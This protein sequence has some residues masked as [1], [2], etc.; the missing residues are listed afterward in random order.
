[1]TDKKSEAYRA[2]VRLLSASDKTPAALVSRLVG[3]GFDEGE[4]NDAVLRLT[5]E[6]YVNE[7]RLAENTVQRLYEQYYGEEYIVSYMTE[8]QFSEDALDSARDMM[9]E[10]DFNKKAKEY[11]TSLIRAGKSRAQALSALSRRGYTVYD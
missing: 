1:M 7:T 10:L 2:A 11:Y 8:K 5:A 4:A 6:G 3:K 9:K